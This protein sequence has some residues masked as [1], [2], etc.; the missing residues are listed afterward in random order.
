MWPQLESSFNLM[1]LGGLEGG[2]HHRKLAFL[3]T[4]VSHLTLGCWGGQLPSEAA[5]LSPGNSSGKTE[6]F[7]AQAYSLG[8]RTGS[9]TVCAA[10][11]EGSISLIISTFHFFLLYFMYF[12][13]YFITNHHNVQNMLVHPIHQYIHAC[14]LTINR[15]NVAG[16]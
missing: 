2:L 5:S 13:P 16:D 6:L 1:H 11:S 8:K 14:N 7:Y 9:G 3:Y 4:S 10:V 12:S 15:W